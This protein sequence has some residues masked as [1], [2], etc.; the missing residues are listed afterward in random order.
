MMPVVDELLEDTGAVLGIAVAAATL[1]TILWVWIGRPVRKEWKTNRD[2]QRT[3]RS[4]WVGVPDR[5][6]VPGHPGVMSSLAEI[7]TDGFQ[8][9]ER[10]RKVE[11]EIRRLR[12]E[13][14]WLLK[15]RCPDQEAEMPAMI[16]FEEG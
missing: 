6:G 5:D 14:D 7:R 1:L 10:V 9:A 15:H 4:D 13:V 8:V 16:E 3:F 11:R 12:N 2:F